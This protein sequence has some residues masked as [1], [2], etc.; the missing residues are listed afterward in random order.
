MH[1]FTLSIFSWSLFQF[2]LNL[3]V[4]KGQSFQ[5]FQFDSVEKNSIDVNVE[6]EEEDEEESKRESS[7]QKNVI[8][9]NLKPTKSSCSSCLNFDNEIWSII[10]TLIF[11]DG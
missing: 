7:A 3:V 2:S 10:I 6:D 9:I 4:R 11:Q 8:K 5:S 1:Y